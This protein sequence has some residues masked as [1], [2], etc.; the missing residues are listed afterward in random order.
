MGF[1]SK[2]NLLV[3]CSTYVADVAESPEV[4]SRL[5]L[6]AFGTTYRLFVGNFEDCYV[7]LSQG[8]ENGRNTA[9]IIMAVIGPTK[10][11]VNRVADIL[12]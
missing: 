1:G 5:S 9:A 10:S 7:T 12:S 8:V 3:L 6:T 4:M 11:A 2:K